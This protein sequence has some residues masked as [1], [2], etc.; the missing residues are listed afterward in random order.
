MI[1]DRENWTV[2]PS[3][4]TQP[5]MLKRG[6]QAVATIYRSEYAERITAALDELEG[7]PTRALQENA[8]RRLFESAGHLLAAVN[9]AQK[10][11]DARSIPESI[12]ENLA[13]SL[14]AL[15]SDSQEGA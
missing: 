6:D 15:G 2:T 12:T 14:K 7:V 3:T 4:L 1:A 9:G 5:H 13:A 10:N 8:L 11:G